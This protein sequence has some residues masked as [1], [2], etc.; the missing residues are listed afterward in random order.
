MKKYLITD[1]VYY[2]SNPQTFSKK[3]SNIIKEKNPDFICLRDKNT[4]SYEELAISLKNIVRDKIKTFL[5]TD[6]KLAKK[7]DFYGIHLPSNRLEDIQ[8][9]KDLDLKVIVSTHTLEEA[10]KAERL[11]ADFITYSPI[12]FTPNKGEPKGLEKL[13]EI[14]DKININCFALGGIC[15][16]EQVQLCK[17]TGVYGFASIR[18]FV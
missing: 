13:K 7:L 11:G 6:F 18:Y 17:K 8:K 2:S 15:E 12:F 5:H 4:D 9:A 16:D 10:K 14:N 1:P 3:L